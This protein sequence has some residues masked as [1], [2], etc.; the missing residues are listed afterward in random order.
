MCKFA[1]LKEERSQFLCILLLGK[2]FKL[3]VCLPVV[4]FVN[5][6]D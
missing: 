2:N 5:I 4:L 1:Y 6:I 3:H